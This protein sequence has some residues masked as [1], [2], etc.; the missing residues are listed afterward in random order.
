MNQSLVTLLQKRQI[1]LET[2][3]SASSLKDELEQMIAR[4]AGV[5]PGAGLSRPGAGLPRRP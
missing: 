1:T 4:G 5:V 2:A 3:M